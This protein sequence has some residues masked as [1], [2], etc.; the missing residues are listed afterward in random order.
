[1]LSIYGKNAVVLEEFPIPEERL[2]LDF[3]LPHHKLAF[4]YQG[5]QHDSF[6]KFF[7]GDKDGFKRSLAR[8]ERKKLWCQ[9]NDISLI[10]VRGVVSAETLKSLIVEARERE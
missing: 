3:Y 2:W 6:N 7:H 5:Q 1:V 8:D 10:E 4:E 9:V